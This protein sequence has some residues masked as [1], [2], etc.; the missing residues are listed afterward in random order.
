LVL[1]ACLSISAEDILDAREK[2]RNELTPFRMA[3]QKLTIALRPL[4]RDNASS[5]QLKREA[6]FLA[7]AQVEP[8]LRIFSEGS[9]RKRGNSGGVCLE[10]Q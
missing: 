8:A 2:L 10:L 6:R 5:E 7:E 9:N 3:M 1:P 4:L